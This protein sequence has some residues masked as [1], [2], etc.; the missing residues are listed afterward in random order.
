MFCDVLRL[1]IIKANAAFVLPNR[2]NT[3]S[4]TFSP[5]EG[6]SAQRSAR[7]YLIRVDAKDVLP[8]GG[9]L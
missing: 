8:V 2:K 1:S 9:V 7:K 5:S 6:H 4:S 3:A